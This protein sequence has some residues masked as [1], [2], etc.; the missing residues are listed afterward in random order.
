[1]T[2]L[3]ITH[4]GKLPKDGGKRIAYQ[5]GDAVFVPG[6]AGQFSAAALKKSA[7][8]DD[9]SVGAVNS[10]DLPVYQSFR[11]LDAWQECPFCG[12]SRFEQVRLETDQGLRR[13]YRCDCR[14]ELMR[15]HP[16]GMSSHV[17]T[18]F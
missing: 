7:Q 1:M 6:I 11:T 14:D 3:V 5:V 9:H 4:N 13:L 12:R 16:N 17:W 18:K 2:I 10:A 15:R 8:K